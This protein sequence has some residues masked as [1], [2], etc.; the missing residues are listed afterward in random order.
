MK[1]TSI[2]SAISGLL[3]AGS[4]V[5]AGPA[6]A[7]RGDAGDGSGTPAGGSSHSATGERIGVG[8]FTNH[9]PAVGQHGELPWGPIGAAPAA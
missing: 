9:D 2:I 5:L 8:I 3:V 4:L 1:H 6:S 7:H